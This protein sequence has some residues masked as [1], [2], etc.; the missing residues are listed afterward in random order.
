MQCIARE[1]CRYGTLIASGKF[2]VK[3]RLRCRGLTPPRSFFSVRRGARQA[4][5]AKTPHDEGMSTHVGNFLKDKRR[6]TRAELL[7][8]L[9]PNKEELLETAH[10]VGGVFAVGSIMHIWVT[11]VCNVT[12]VIGP[13][14]LPTFHTAGDIVLSD[15]I[16]PRFTGYTVGDV[17]IAK[18]P[19]DPKKQVCKR[20]RAREG[21]VVK[22]PT[23]ENGVYKYKQC[24]IPPGHVWL[25]GDNPNNSTD[26]RQYG[27]VPITMLK[28]R[29]L[30]R[31]F[32]F[33]SVGWVSH[34]ENKSLPGTVVF[35]GTA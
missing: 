29:I 12:M 34:H 27:P 10:F 7:A 21:D 26:S 15:A 19:T 18:S 17:V 2:V 35:N 20:I 9:K 31:V 8:F 14:M 5:G 33:T 28:Y 16:S 1:G 4:K 32:P 22:I 24:S 23:T 11:Y 30:C 25:Q 13:S 6:P 3:S